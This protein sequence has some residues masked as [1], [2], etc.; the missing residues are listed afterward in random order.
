[1]MPTPMEQLMRHLMVEH[2]LDVGRLP[3]PTMSELAEM[4]DRQPHHIH[5]DEPWSPR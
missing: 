5:R 1:M 3:N 4:H 2:R